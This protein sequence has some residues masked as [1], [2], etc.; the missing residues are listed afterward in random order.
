MTH[1]WGGKYWG[2][3]A[4]NSLS[5]VASQVRPVMGGFYLST[6]FCLAE[7]ARFCELHP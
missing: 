1:I 3:A 6:G 7:H 5:I 4:P 2:Q